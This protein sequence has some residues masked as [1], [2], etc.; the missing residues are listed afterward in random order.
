MLGIIGIVPEEV[1]ILEGELE[2]EE[3]TLKVGGVEI[4]L[5]RG[6]PALIGA[7]LETLNFFDP[8]FKKEVYVLLAGDRGRGDGSRLLYERLS[9]GKIPS[10]FKVLVFHYFMPDADLCTKALFSLEKLGGTCFF[11]A[12]AGFMYAVKMAGML[13]RINLMTPDV[14]ELA[15]LA[16][17]K[18]PHPFYTRGFLQE[19]EKREELIKRIY[20]KEVFPEYLLVK[21]EEDLVVRRGEVVAR[22]GEPRVEELEAIG[23][24]GDTL[25]G[26]V[27][28]LI[29]YGMEPEEACELGAKVNRLAGKLASPTPA[30]SIREILKFIKPSLKSLIS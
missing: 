12:D 7:V 11:I 25:L 8:A 9:S 18:A 23:G 1:G 14:G 27:S 19:V 22:V 21:G 5:E 13:D 24:T 16:D 6:T 3:R 28:A 26:V 29:W 4:S 30:S 17:E 2:K 10:S 20:A 15:F